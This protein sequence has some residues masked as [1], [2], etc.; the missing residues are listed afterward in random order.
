MPLNLVIYFLLLSFTTLTAYKQLRHLSNADKIIAL[1]LAVAL[2]EEIVAFMAMRLHGNNLWLSHIYCPLELLLVSLYFDKSIKLFHRYRIGVAVGLSGLLL[3]AINSIFIQ[4]LETMNSYFLL[5]EGCIIIMFSLL[6]YHQILMDEEKLPYQFA[7]F[8]ISTC[9]LL[10][11]SAT[12][13]G[14]GVY[15]VVKQDD[16]ILNPIINKVVAAAN[17]SFY[18]GLMIVFIRYKKLRPSGA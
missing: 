2:V 16:F 10:F 13:T 15:N 3:A 8:W 12:F 18:I 17:Y 7:Q 5:F 1:L 9:F 11:W 6:S 14:W 4:S